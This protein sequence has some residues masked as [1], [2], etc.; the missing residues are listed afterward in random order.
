MISKMR[1]MAPTIMIVILISFVIGTIF[2]NWGMNRGSSSGSRM[3]SVGKINGREIPLSYFDREVSAERQKQERRGTDDDQY[4]AHLIPGRV[5]EQQVQQILMKDFFEKID[6]Y[7]S[8]DEVFDYIKRN[9]PSG[10]D[11]ASELMTNGV[12]D[13]TKY[14]ALLNDPRTYEYNPGFRIL[15]R[16]TREL[17]IP[18]Q[19]LE[20][21]LSAPL[22]P[23]KAEFE[24]LYKEENEKAVF[25][26]AYINHNAV[27]IDGSRITADMVTKY[28]TAHR[29]AFVG[30]ELVDLYVAKFPKK[31]TARD[32]QVYYQELLDI[33]N[34]ILS[35]KDV[36]RAE[37]FA[38]EAKVS[39]DDEESAQN[40]GDLGFI[41]RGTMPPEFDAVAFKIDTCTLS[42]PVKTRFGYHLIM[43][44]KRRKRGAGDEVKVRHILRKIVPTIETSDAL[45]EK[46][47]SL[48]RKMIDEGF[49]AAVREAAK[50]DT[51]VIF[52]ST[53]LIAR[54]ASIPGIGY[55]SGLG[56][57]ILGLEGK[58][59]ETVSER[60]ENSNGFYLFSVKQRIPKGVMP[61]A[62]AT[63]RIRK[64]LADS[65][66]RE[67][68][69]SFAEAWS[70]K[71]GEGIPLATLEKYDKSI[72]SGITDTV[73][74][75]KAIPG[76]GADS[77]VAAVAFELPVGKRSKLIDWNGT[78]FLVRP[79][80]KGPPA[81]VPWGSPQLSMIGARYMAQLRER[82]SMEWYTDYKS[83]QK[84]QCNIDKI[85][86]D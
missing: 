14:V 56:R 4:Q 2:F 38:E 79:L 82:L 3:N 60:L 73:T 42:N 66:Y 53:G 44:E 9:P 43:V 8:A 29:S 15:E 27:R 59:S 34:K 10:L 17:V 41:R 24:Y 62:A 68:L 75:L 78:Y 76:V 50:L 85:Y 6:L 45:T 11:T 74:R 80:W 46:V 84:I 65:L 36:S 13:T 18:M 16:Q 63:P 86:I 51:A 52:D 31:A 81:T 58:E 40:G 28:Y 25:E 39:S 72:T 48:R 5:W 57:F 30:D 20:S 33:R 83:R 12:F 7:A 55:V 35:E 47:D 61:L 71:V 1:A 23:T 64:I 54:N 77:K 19:K 26:Y 69:R 70:G 49:V 67:A 37:A 22:L 32:E 21:L